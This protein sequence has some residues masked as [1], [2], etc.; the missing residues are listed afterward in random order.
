MLRA[1]FLMDLN[2]PH[3][4]MFDTTDYV[5]QKFSTA[6]TLH[7]SSYIISRTLSVYS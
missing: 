7:M 4:T 1:E 3:S 6:T 2:M 5:V